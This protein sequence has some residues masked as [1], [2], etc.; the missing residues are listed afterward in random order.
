MR[1]LCPRHRGSAQKVFLFFIVII[2]KPMDPEFEFKILKGW[3]LESNIPA[4]QFI[5][6][7]PTSLT[8]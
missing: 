6:L 7:S 2:L 1:R 8:Y 5:K 3:L 4:P